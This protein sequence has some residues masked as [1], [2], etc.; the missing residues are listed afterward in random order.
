MIVADVAA[1]HH[2]AA[3]ICFLIAVILAT[4]AALGSFRPT[5]DARIISLGWLALASTALGLLIL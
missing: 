1:G 3:D 2:A 4:L 5:I